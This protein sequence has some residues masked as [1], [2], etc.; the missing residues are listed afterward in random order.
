MKYII[1]KYFKIFCCR[2]AK[3]KI[4]CKFNAYHMMTVISIII[5]QAT[6]MILTIY[7]YETSAF[8]VLHNHNLAKMV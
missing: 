6:T 5:C 4:K 3:I 1:L 8:A 2:N 7:S